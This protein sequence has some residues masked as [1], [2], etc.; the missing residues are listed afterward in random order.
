MKEKKEFGLF[1]QAKRKEKG[2]SQVEL[3]AMLYVSESAVS[4]W[5]RGVTYPDITLITDICNILEINEHEFLSASNDLEYRKMK[6]E[7][8][9]YR[10]ISNAI[11]YSF[12]IAYLI[13]ILTCFIVN[14]ATEKTLSWFFIVFFA[15]GLAFTIVPSGSR[16]VKNYK[17][18]VVSTSAL[19]MLLMLLLTTCIHTSGTWF[20]LASGYI[21]FAFATVFVPIYLRVYKRPHLLVKSIYVSSMTVNLVFLLLA[22]LITA[23]YTSGTWF[24]IVM[25]S[26]LI[27]YAIAVGPVI[28]KKFDLPKFMKNNTALVILSIVYLLTILLVLVV[29]ITNHD[30]DLLSTIIIVSYPFVGMLIVMLIHLY[31]NDNKFI[32][33][34]AILFTYTS[35]TFFFKFFISLVIREDVNYGVNLL[36]WSENFIEGN[37]NFTICLILLFA[38][39]IIFIIGMIKRIEGEKKK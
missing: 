7:A 4:K 20:L 35:F 32:K 34:S 14:L 28:I 3:A 15:I 10:R 30:M 2:L 8:K 5:E 9:K 18:L 6:K 26:L 1:I 38:I 12:T 13:A 23:I 24:F 22:L 17:L 37:I 31:L 16:F 29:K 19:L 25:V 21:V 36:N 11:F 39:V 33:L 27:V